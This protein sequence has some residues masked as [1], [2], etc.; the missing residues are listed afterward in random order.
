MLL[1]GCPPYKTCVAQAIA[2]LI[3]KGNWKLVVVCPAQITA[4]WKREAQKVLHDFGVKVHLIGQRRRQPDGRG[5]WRKVGKPVLDVIRAMEEPNPAVLIMSYETAKLGA[6]WEHAPTLQRKPVRY[7]QEIEEVESLD[8]YPYERITLVEQEIVQCEAVLCCPDCGEVLMN[9]YGPLKAVDDLGKRKRHCPA[10]GTPLWQQVPFKY[11]GRV[12]IADFL[13]RRYSGRYNLILDEAHH[14]KGADTDLGY[15][16]ADLVAGARKA[17]AMTGTVYAGKASSIFYLLYRLFPH[18][19]QWYG[20]NEVQRF[21]EHHGLQET[22]TTVKSSDRYHSTY[23]YRR[24]NVRM[25]EIPGVSPG[26]VTMLLG[27]TAFLKL[28]DVG[29]ALPPYTE[30]RLPIPLDERLT[31]GLRD[32]GVIYDD[33]AHLARE[34]KPGLLSSWL[35]ASLGWLDCPVDETLEARGKEGQI[36]ATYPIEGVLESNEAL[37]PEPLAKD[38]ALMELIESELAQD[39]GVGVYFA[40][41]NRRDWMGRIQQLLQE[42]GI[43]SEILRQNTCKPEDRE[44]WYRLFVYRCRSR[45]QEPVLLANGNLVREGLDLIELP[46][47]IETGVEYRLNDL[48]QRDRRSWRLTQDRPVRVIFLYYQ[49]TWQETALQLVAAKLK[50]AHMVEGN[51]AEGLAAM[52]LDDGNLMDA[53]MK[54]V[55]KGRPRQTAWSGMQVAHVTRPRPRPH[56]TQPQRPA[57]EPEP[58]LEISEVA[59]EGGAIQY[60]FLTE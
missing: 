25:R 41:V 11:G 42:K 15:A 18:F 43:Y 37:L 51:L 47:L 9:E 60:T 32:I 2:A 35:Y 26:M 5:Q 14:A 36:I 22:I 53:L 58:D 21:I 3:G 28:A 40:Q 17:I 49:D 19:R 39:R 45:G 20:Y 48:R 24:E 27:N 30:E 46:T 52:D 10:C 6:R 31:N 7:R 12:A 23:G 54:A 33:A 38:Q 55:A 44:R 57:P 34:G 16:S 8:H 56:P 1:A 13:N 50:A 4:K 29:F 59:L